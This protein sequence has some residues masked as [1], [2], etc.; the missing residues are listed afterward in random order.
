MF[1]IVLQDVWDITDGVSEKKLVYHCEN[2]NSRNNVKV[3]QN[4]LRLGEILSEFNCGPF[5]KKIESLRPSCQKLEF[6]PIK[7]WAWPKKGAATIFKIAAQA[8]KF[9]M[10]V[11]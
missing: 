10:G 11:N 5:G 4:D 8:Q 9:C 7:K 2:P 6:C 3:L 1:G